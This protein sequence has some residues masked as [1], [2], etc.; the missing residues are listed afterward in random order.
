M[1]HAKNKIFVSFYLSMVVLGLGAVV[2]GTLGYCFPNFYSVGI[3]LPQP[4][5]VFYPK[6]SLWMNS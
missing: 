3:T 5:I 2:M 1:T 4:T 6:A